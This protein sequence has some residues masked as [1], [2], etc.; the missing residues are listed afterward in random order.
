M[1]QMSA[2]AGGSGIAALAQSMA[3]QGALQAQKAS[4][5]IGAQ[6]SQNQKLAAEGEQKI[7]MATA[8][9]GS[10]IA[11]AKAGEQSRLDTQK[12][13]SDMDIQ[14]KVLDAD[15]ALQSQR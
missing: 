3:N 5:S 13:Q 4:A 1:S 9:E 2:A 11:M 7:Q 10:K 15:Q 6:E 12:R 14:N 8:G